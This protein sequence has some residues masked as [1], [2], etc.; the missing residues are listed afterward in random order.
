LFGNY[1]GLSSS[2]EPHLIDGR[3]APGVSRAFDLPFIG[4]TA[5]GVPDNGRLQTD[6]PHVFNTFGAYIFDWMG[7]KT[8]STEI[9]AFQTITSGQPQTTT[10]YGASSVTPQILLGRGDLGRSPV[11]SQTDLNFT[12]RYRMEKLTLAFDLNFLNV[13]DQSTVTAIY[14][15]M[16]PSTAQVNGPALGFPNTTTGY[17]NGYTSGALLDAIL[18]RIASAPDR[19]D[20]RYKQPYLYQSPRTVRFG[21]RLL[22]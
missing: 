5:K 1:S 12:H 6:R 20:I 14:T 2:D 9:S 17:A 4:F 15:V 13:W 22:F 7:N 11:F 18:A 10:I 21:F 19:S 3:L 8:N 16:N